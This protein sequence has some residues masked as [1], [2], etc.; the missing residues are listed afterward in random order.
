[1]LKLENIIRQTERAKEYFENKVAFT[2]G[3]VELKEM[4]EKDSDKIQVIDVRTAE[5][6][7]K[8]HIPSAVSIPAKDITMH[9]NK[10]SK[11]KINIVYCY[12]QQCHL[13]AKAALV[14]AERGFPVVELEGGFNEWKN[15][16]YDI[17]SI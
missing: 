17:V 2:V 4:I 1:M 14:L 16:D 7:Q 12:S 15:L 13:A 3:P 5:Y 9:M 8:G 11:E 10:L 6:Y